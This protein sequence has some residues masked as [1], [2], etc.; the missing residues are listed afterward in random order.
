MV[1]A[2]ARLQHAIDLDKDIRLWHSITKAFDRCGI[3]LV[4][5]LGIFYVYALAGLL[6]AVGIYDSK[7]SAIWALLAT[8]SLVVS[9]VHDTLIWFN[10]FSARPW[11]P[12][13]FGA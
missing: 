10:L 1:E 9:A 4:G 11:I 7:R 12:Y 2:K 8:L 6:C 5:L 3:G 13:G